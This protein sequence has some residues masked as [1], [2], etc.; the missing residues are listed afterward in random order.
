VVP[1]A[2]ALAAAAV[3]AAASATPRLSSGAFGGLAGVG[4]AAPLLA[5]AAASR[6]E[7]EL[8]ARNRPLTDEHL[9]AL[10]PKAG[11]RV[12]PPPPSYVPLRDPAR[13]LTAAPTP[14]AT[15]GFSMEPT[16]ARESY[17]VPLGPDGT[18]AMEA[19]P[20]SSAPGLPFLKPEDAQFFAAL[21]GEAGRRAEGELTPEELKART[22]ATLLLKIKNGAPPQRK[23]ALR[24]IAERARELGAA[25]LFSALLPLLMSPSLEDGERHVLVKAVE[26][27]L[28][29]LDDAV[30]PFAHKILT[31]VA[32][33]LIEDDFYVRVEGRELIANLAKACGLA[34]MIS[35]MRPDID[36]PDEFVRNT[37][38]RALAVVCGALGI[39]A[40]LPFLRAVT[41]SKKSADARH[42]GCKVVQQTAVLVGCAVL[43]HLGALVGAVGPCLGDGEQRVR[44]MAALALAALAE[45]AAPYGIEAFDPVLAPLFLGAKTA[46]GKALAAHLR[47]AGAVIP[48][49]D[50]DIAA[51][52]TRDLMPALVREFAS[53]DDEMRK[54]VLRTVAQC[55]ACEGVEAGYL[56]GEVAPPFFEHF[57]TRRVALDRRNYRAVVDTTLALALRVG[58]GDVAARVGPLLKDEADTLRRMAM[59]ALEKVLTA[60]GASDV[61]PRL[62]DE[63]VDGALYAF[64]E[65]GVSVGAEAGG[66]AASAEA[67]VVLSGFGTLVAALGTRAKPY[68]PQVAGT[69]KWRLNNKAPLI[70]M[71]AADLVQRVAP[72][73]KA[74]GEDPLMAHLGNVLFECLGE[75]YPDVLG[76]L[77]GALRAIVA[78]IGL[79][80]MQPPIKDLLPR[81]TPIL[82]NRSEKVQENCIDL[83]GRIADRGADA[84]SL[85]EWVR[86]CFELLE[87]LHAPR[88]AIRRAAVNTFGYI[89][90]AVGPQ[91]VLHH[92]INNLKVAERTSRV[93]TTVAIGIVA[94][95]CA[96]LTVLPALLNEYRTPDMNVQN[97][98]LKS[99][100]F[101][102]EYIG[103]VAK[104]Y[105]HAATPLLV[106]ALMDRD[107]VHRQ[108][109]A[110]CVKHL[111]L[112]LQGAGAEDALLHLLNYLWPNIY[113][114][115]PH[116]I[117]AVFEA[118]EALRVS[119]G[120]GVV[121]SYLRAGLFHPA[122][123]VREVHWRLYNNLVAYAGHALPAWLPAVPGEEGGGG[124]GGKYERSVLLLCA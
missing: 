60:L 118:V 32:P 89:A 54:V 103:E 117:G 75:E 97:G 88:K 53:P 45:A 12:L 21:T 48:L 116:V 109:A 114:K 82:K 47:A 5:A 18:E 104:D 43:P 15:P 85:R 87:L 121:F 101:M 68:F 65:Q 77:L 120:P 84:V 20:P 24:A 46:R 27:V 28:Y 56:R 62:A 25:P 26:R 94:E 38:A 13:K 106:D 58:A 98:V 108:I 99:L 23:S 19:A 69:I 8:A 72:V 119:L 36:S 111:A 90:K 92:L 73:M 1:S 33:M 80:A 10:L 55:I 6:A 91:E 39:G 29:A 7:A 95:T 100:S 16:P 86:I 51:Q 113:E 71:L 3:A 123:R 115:S 105:V 52:V 14:L 59:E 78:V 31:V 50:A 93:C 96:P 122:R 64:Q 9:D 81:L 124:G 83:V 4:A 22:V 107:A 110:N 74:C 61:P 70:R 112:G 40:L 57:W 44:V 79:P 42:T 66:P 11:F 34:T 67:R 2:L 102:F 76:S 37:T 49:M 63:L 17:G 30:R 41:A 35:V